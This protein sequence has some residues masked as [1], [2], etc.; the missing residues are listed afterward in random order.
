MES[1]FVILFYVTAMGEL[2]ATGDAP[3][4]D[5]RRYN[6]FP[7]TAKTLATKFVPQSKFYQFN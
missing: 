5:N 4:L 7:G 2:S 6:T 1:H 3:V